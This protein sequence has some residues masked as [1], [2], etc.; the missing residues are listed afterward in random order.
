MKRSCLAVLAAVLLI[1][2]AALSE[3]NYL[4]KQAKELKIKQCLP[5]IAAVSGFVMGDHKA[6]GNTLYDSKDANKGPLLSAAETVYS[7][8]S[9]LSLLSFFPKAEGSCT[10]TYATIY[11]FD[12]PCVAKVKTFDG[13]E[14][15]GQLQADISFLKGKVADAYLMPA[16]KGCIAVKQELVTG[17][18]TP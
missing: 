10:A 12:E 1:P 18:D 5:K 4:L 3:D 11:Y 13:F 15:Q 6:G 8:A 2:T 16:G 9:T 14:Y 17:S 7:D